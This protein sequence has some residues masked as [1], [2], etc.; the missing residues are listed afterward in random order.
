MPVVVKLLRAEDVELV[1][2]IDRSERVDVEYEVVEGR[3]R[4]RPVSMSE[5]PG[6]DRT[7]DGSHSF[8]AKIRFCQ[9]SLLRGGQLLGGYLGEEVA[10]LAVVEPSFES[11]LAWLSFLHV[12]RPYRRE[13][14]GTALWTS[15]VQM[16][17]DASATRLYVSA[18]PTG[19]AVGFNLRQGC[20]LAV[21]PHAGLFEAEPEDIQLV[22]RL[23]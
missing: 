2:L 5:V 6:W 14:V 10:G 21:P 11:P 19:S 8:R 7:G 4:T 1:R 22:L 18:T 13:G 20:V 9:E 12:S 16:A 23:E 15:A 17:R 3:L